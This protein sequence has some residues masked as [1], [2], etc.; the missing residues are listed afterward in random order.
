M[1]YFLF[2]YPFYSYVIHAGFGGASVRQETKAVTLLNKIIS[3]R[4]RHQNYQV[5]WLFHQDQS[6]AIDYSHQDRRIIIE[7]SDLILNAGT[8]W[9]DMRRAQYP[10]PQNILE[11]LPDLTELVLGGFHQYDC[12]ERIARHSHTQGIATHI[13]E[14]TTDLFFSSYYLG[15]PIRPRTSISERGA[16]LRA[17]FERHQVPLEF[18][19]AERQEK[20]WLMPV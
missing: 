15:C 12:V 11:Q 18:T 10:D 19:R 3:Q 16:V 1:P 20:P 17:F 4:Y 13:D 7:R 8:T 9:D 2:L 5:A 6:A 14:D